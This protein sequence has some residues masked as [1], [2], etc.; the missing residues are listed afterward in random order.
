M[1]KSRAA[2]TTTGRCH[3]VKRNG[4][5]RNHPGYARPTG[6]LKAWTSRGD[7][8][9]LSELRVRSCFTTWLSAVCPHVSSSPHLICRRVISRWRGAMRVRDRCQ[10]QFH[11]IP[12]AGRRFKR[13]LFRPAV[14][15]QR[16]RELEWRPR[17]S[18]HTLQEQA[19][20][21]AWITV[22]TTP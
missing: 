20:A 14:P 13:L 12:S 21:G 3:R 11:T 22:Q 4:K 18:E 9:E 6:L 1:A 7:A 16:R 10:G 19:N 2:L 5:R 17:P 15:G 8:S